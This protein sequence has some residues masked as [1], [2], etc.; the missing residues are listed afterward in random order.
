[1]G[2]T[3]DS[4]YPRQAPPAFSLAEDPDR[5]LFARPGRRLARWTLPL[6]AALLIAGVLAAAWPY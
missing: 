3:E 2:R 4:S 5:L 1:M 6:L